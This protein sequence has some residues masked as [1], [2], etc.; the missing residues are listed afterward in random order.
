MKLSR[1]VS[2]R[3]PLRPAAKRACRSCSRATASTGCTTRRTSS[4]RSV[5]S[6]IT[7]STRNGMS[8]LT[9]SITEMDLE[10]RRRPSARRRLEADF[11]RTGLA[12][13]EERPGVARQRREFGRLVDDE[14]L[15]RGAAEQQ[16]GEILLAAAQQLGSQRS[17]RARRGPF[18]RAALVDQPWWF[19]SSRKSIAV[20]AANS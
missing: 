18:L 4:P 2:L 14:V 8:S 15:R 6:P 17:T 16:R 19:A 5:S 11:R 1:C 3:L 12:R 20:A 13:G 10:T 9:I 7:E